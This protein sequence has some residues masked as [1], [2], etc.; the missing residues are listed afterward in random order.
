MSLSQPRHLVARPPAARLRRILCALAAFVASLVLCFTWDFGG[1]RGWHFDTARA[2]TDRTGIYDLAKAR[3]LARVI[4][5]IRSHYVAPERIDPKRMAIAA[6]ARVQ[7]EVPEVRFQ[8]DPP[9]AAGGVNGTNGAGK[10]TVPRALLVTV[11]EVTREFTLDQVDDLYQLNWKLMEV[12]EFFERHLP[13]QVDLE[14]L[15]YAAVNGLLSTLDPHT[16]LMTP[17]FYRELQLSQKGRFGGLGISV[18][19]VD[20]YLVIQTVMAGTP[21]AEAGVE[22]D[23]KIVQI[24][25]VSTIGLGLDE[26]VNLLRGEPDTKVTLWVRRK[27][28]KEA[29]PFELTRREIQL[30]SVESEVLGDGIGWVYIR[31]F[32]ET[33]D[34]DLRVAL[35]RLDKMPGGLKGLVL[36]LRDNPGGL[37]EKAIAVSNTF[38]TSGTI[39][40]TVREGGKERDESHAT[41][42]DTRANLPLVV[43][44]NRGSASASE[45]VAGALK[46]NDRALVVGQ[47]TFGKGSVQVVYRIDEAALK[48][49]VA[50]YLTPGDISIQGVGIVPDIDLVTL[51]VPE[52]KAGEP[53]D[54]RMDLHPL[55]ESLGGEASLSSHLS[56]DKTRSEKPSIVLRLLEDLRTPTHRQRGQDGRVADAA[57]RLAKDVLRQAPATDRKQALVQL[58]GFFPE[59]QAEEDRHLE[60]ALAPYGVSWKP[61]PRP[62]A[63]AQKQLAATLTAPA[64]VMAGKPFQV[65]LEV[66]NAGKRPMGR[67]HAELVSGIGALDGRE[68][69]LGWLEAGKSLTRSFTMTLPAGTA[70]AGDRVAARLFVDGEELAAAPA[71]EAM[72]SV[73]PVPPPVFALAY[74]IDDV[75]E[76]ARAGAPPRPAVTGTLRGN[77]DGLL[78]RGERVRLD[79]FVTNVGAGPAGQALATLRNE[80]GPEVFIHLGRQELGP[81][82]AG[83]TR[84]ASFEVEVLPGLKAR[85]VALTLEVSDAAG[86]FGS[87]PASPLELP[88]FPDALP[89]RVVASGFAALPSIQTSLHAGAS[90]ESPEVALCGASVV[91]QVTGRAGDWL[92]VTWTDLKQGLPRA[93]WLP[94]ERARVADTGGVSRDGI[95]AMIPKRPPILEL[96]TTPT[97]T[98][99][100]DL[101]LKGV[102]RYAAGSGARRL[103]YIFRGRDKVFFKAADAGQIPVGRNVEG[104]QGA[105]NSADFDANIALELGRNDI[106]VVA[107]EGD[108]SVSR[109][110]FS[111]FR[112]K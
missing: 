84:R 44:V 13:P 19:E 70:R 48:L 50:Q 104:S 110:T 55:P 53:F 9:E 43:L 89:P 33:T 91:L 25:G 54:G 92:E 4:G 73:A 11:G 77:G 12:F 37:L 98:S 74:Q 100:R 2:K 59:R 64:E 45:I 27:G 79:V 69:P 107:R 111:V 22:V 32:Q 66:K 10:K 5:H 38:L 49:T 94:A 85:L 101:P 58:Q 61:S 8:V 86:A 88:V 63:A 7:S 96:E 103:I 93:G 17:R 99:E 57:V 76:V 112:L 24:G 35:A 29:K 56:S 26:V 108:Q 75:V 14:A 80:T 68:V 23:D 90:R 47:T 36:D 81:M 40:T 83:E 106:T 52:P 62:P 28:W 78:Q 16:V 42:A 41:Q 34:E 39:V 6:L 20:G 102:A 67:V 21:A 82:A 3:M 51:R 105:S 65:S 97:F 87:V 60:A 18:G 72:V 109:T 15:E 1:D 31:G 71:A 30:P 46:R 95:T